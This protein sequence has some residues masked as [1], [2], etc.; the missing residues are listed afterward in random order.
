MKINGLIEIR[1]RLGSVNIYFSWDYRKG[2]CLEDTS[3]DSQSTF[4]SISC[5]APFAT[6]IV[7]NSSADEG[8]SVGTAGG[9]RSK[10]TSNDIV[11]PSQTN[12]NLF[13]VVEVL[14]L[15]HIKVTP[16]KGDEDKGVIMLN[17]GHYLKFV[18]NSCHNLQ[19][20]NETNSLHISRLTFRMSIKEIQKE[21]WRGMMSSDGKLIRP[22]KNHREISYV[23]WEPFIKAKET[24][25]ITWI[26]KSCAR[27]ISIAV[28]FYERVYSYPDGFID[29][30]F[31]HPHSNT[32]STINT[33]C[34][35]EYLKPKAYDLFYGHDYVILHGSHMKDH[36][37]MKNLIISCVHCQSSIGV[38]LK[39]DDRETF[40]LWSDAVM[41]RCCSSSSNHLLHDT[42]VFP[43]LIAAGP[44]KLKRSVLFLLKLIQDV[45]ELSPI[46]SPM[47]FIK[48]ILRTES[49]HSLLLNICESNL[50]V[51]KF[52]RG[53]VEKHKDIEVSGE[54][55]QPLI[56]IKLLYLAD[57]LKENPY[58]NEMKLLRRWQNDATV[59]EVNVS[60]YFIQDI[61][62][63][64]RLNGELLP[65]IHRNVQ[66]E[67]LYWRLSYLFY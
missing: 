56:A 55:V 29:D 39:D 4:S 58:D 18:D 8:K 67:G 32:R 34:L 16:P 7:K 40:K 28:P 49:C 5:S 59:M 50:K 65:N 48:C 31:C 43:P 38:L 25:N 15:E 54:D 35:S 27:S 10:G 57:A 44:Q 42:Q 26:C 63:E 51:L 62:N 14:N 47:A 20:E 61:L 9:D 17:V 41:I 12:M 21:R 11:H 64:L 23:Q 3:R 19:W 24:N 53:K 37:H 66:Y 6:G 2:S 13:P 30:F 36:V 46:Q 22:E 33:E 60:P 45:S 1:E 52:S